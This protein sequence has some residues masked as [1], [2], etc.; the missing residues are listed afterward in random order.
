MI[1][2]KEIQFTDE[3]IQVNSLSGEKIGLASLSSGE[4]HF[5][6]ILVSTLLV[7]ESSLIVDEPEISMHVD[8]QKDLIKSLRALNA[9]AQFIFATHSPEIMADVPNDKIFRI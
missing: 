3:S 4:K 8:W 7:G 5:L 1:A 9:E 2:N 6:R